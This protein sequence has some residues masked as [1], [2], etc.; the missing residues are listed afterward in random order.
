MSTPNGHFGFGSP[1][2]AEQIA[3]WDIG[4]RGVKAVR[5]WLAVSVH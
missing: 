3:G 4:A 1:A 5:H 2:T